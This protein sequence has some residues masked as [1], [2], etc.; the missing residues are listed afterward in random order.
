MLA[1]SVSHAPAAGVRSQPHGSSEKS[2]DQQEQVVPGV[3]LPL[4]VCTITLSFLTMSIYLSRPEL[5]VQQ[6]KR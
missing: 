6:I 3:S 2:R 4:A 5:Q 1:P